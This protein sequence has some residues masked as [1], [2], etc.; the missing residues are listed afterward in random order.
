MTEQ[1]YFVL[2]KGANPPG[3]TR[4]VPLG[5]WGPV[6]FSSRGSGKITCAVDCAVGRLREGLAMGAG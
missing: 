3:V 1:G 2:K 4:S 5:F 6:G